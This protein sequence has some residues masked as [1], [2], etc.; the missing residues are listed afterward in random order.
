MWR[1]LGLIYGQGLSI[2]RLIHPHRS[3]LNGATFKG[4]HMRT[5][6]FAGN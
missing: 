1:E 3:H 5:L 2:A 6:Y 4:R